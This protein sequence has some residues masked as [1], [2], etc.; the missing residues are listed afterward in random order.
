MKAKK[1]FKAVK[2]VRKI[3][4]KNIVKY[5]NLNLKDFATALSSEAKKSELWKALKYRSE[6][7]N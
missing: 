2:W 6:K 7:V 1:G 5:K 4:D 3:R